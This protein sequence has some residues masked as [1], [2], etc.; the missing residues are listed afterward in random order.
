[1]SRYNDIRY[2]LAASV[3]SSLPFPLN[4]YSYMPKTFIP[5]AAMVYPNTRSINYLQMMSSQSAEWHYTV[6]IVLGEVDEEAAQNLVGDIVSP[7]S[8]VIAAIC[9][10]K[11]P[12]GY[13]VVTDGSVS[14]RQVPGASATGAALYTH[15][16]LHVM[17]KA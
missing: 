10:T 1:M 14:E 6:L 7:D 17:V 2:A 4:V 12:G 5:P 15:A 8:A 16:E 11:I 13:A 3:E 9:N